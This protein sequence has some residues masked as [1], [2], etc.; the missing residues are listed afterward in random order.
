MDD[1]ERS[2]A[3]DALFCCKSMIE[4]VIERVQLQRSVIDRGKYPVTMAGDNI[5][6]FLKR[7]VSW[8]DWGIEQYAPEKISP[9]IVVIAERK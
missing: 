8:A 2:N 9:N 6:H 4:E 5:I 1:E 3:E 7:A